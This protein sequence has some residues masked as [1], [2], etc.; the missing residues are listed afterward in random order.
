MK[1]SFIFLVSF[2]LIFGACSAIKD[3][4]DGENFEIANAGFENWREAPKQG[5]DVPEVGTDLAIIV[6]FWPEEE[7]GYTPKFIIYNGRKSSLVEITNRK[8]N[9]TVMNATI[10]RSSSVMNKTSD[11]VNVSDRLVFTRPDGEVGFLMI[12]EWQNLGK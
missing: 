11:E 9:K 10:I 5:G 12:E 7:E 1:T 3:L 6:R 8:D 4:T 2:I